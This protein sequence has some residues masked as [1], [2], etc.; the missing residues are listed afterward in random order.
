MFVSRRLY[1]P[2]FRLFYGTDCISAGLRD[3][4]C[5]RRDGETTP[6]ARDSH[7]NFSRI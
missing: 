1:L 7:C 3:R 4:A 2:C 5:W 6:V